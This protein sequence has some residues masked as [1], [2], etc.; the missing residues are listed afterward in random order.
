MIG[1]LWTRSER[2]HGRYLYLGPLDE[3]GYV[4]HKESGQMH[5]NILRRY[6]ADFGNV[7]YVCNV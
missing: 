3:Y 7:I 4:K 1:M 5:S 6:V 2:D